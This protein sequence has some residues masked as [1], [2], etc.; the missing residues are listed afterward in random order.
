MVVDETATSKVAMCQL[1]CQLLKD[2]K[3]NTYTFED[4]LLVS[5]PGVGGLVYLEGQSQVIISTR[6][7]T[8]ICFGKSALVWALQDN[9]GRFLVEA[10]NGLARL[11]EIS[12]S[13]LDI[14]DVLIEEDRIYL[15]ATQNN[16]VICLDRNYNLIENW[17]LPGEEDSAHLNSIAIYQGRLIA[18]VFGSF[19]R[20]REYKDGTSGLGKI[21]D[22]RTGET[23]IDGLSQP[24][25]LTVVDD[26]LYFCSSQEKKL[27]VYDGERIINTVLLPGYA[28]GIA[29]GENC[30]YVGISLSRNIENEQHELASGAISIL[31]K[32]SMRCI[33]IKTLPFREVYDIRIIT[34]HADLLSLV[35]TQ[36]LQINELNQTIVAHEEHINELSQIIAV[37]EGHINE[38]NRAIVAREGQIEEIRNSTSWNLTKPVR[39]A[40]RLIHNHKR[41]TQ[42]K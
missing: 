25:S 30:I 37:R 22:V 39:Y 7:S 8:G 18:S 10:K 34:R 38:L 20:N 16:E 29:V 5:S 28:R 32:K 9:G 17:R 24:H 31:D 36:E 12:P 1:M 2:D 33:G 27:H 14:H 6:I 21:F 11:V 26:F 13:P 19:T 4:N 41:L 42:R 35:A 3:L 40:G 23:L 15:A